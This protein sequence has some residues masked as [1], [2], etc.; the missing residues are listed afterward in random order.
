MKRSNHF[1]RVLPATLA[2]TAF[3][4]AVS[5]T[6]LTAGCG[7]GGNSA[8]QSAATRKNASMTMM[9]KWPRPEGTRKIPLA[10]N[11]ITLTIT[12]A[13]GTQTRTV[14]RPGDGLPSRVTFDSLPIRGDYTLTGVAFASAN[15]TGVALA[16]ASTVVQFTLAEPN[17]TVGL[18]L[19]TTIVRLAVTPDP[20][21]LST[22]GAN[23]V[24]L[25]SA[26]GY[27]AE[28]GGNMVPVSVV[29]FEVAD[30]AIATVST[31]PQTGITSI[32]GKA[33]GQTT[34]KAIDTESGEE[35]TVAI[36]VGRIGSRVWPAQTLDGPVRAGAVLST[37]GSVFVGGAEGRLFGFNTVGSPLPNFPVD[38]N[39]VPEQI[40]TP[41]F[42]ASDSFVLTVGDFGSVYA[43]NPNTGALLFD[44]NVNGAY[45]VANG[46]RGSRITATLAIESGSSLIRVPTKNGTIASFAYTVDG[47]G[48]VVTEAPQFQTVTAAASAVTT[49][50]IGPDNSYYV[51]SSTL[52]AQSAQ[53]HAFKQDRTRPYPAVDLDG[54]VAT[55]VALSADGTKAYVA[56]G[57]TAG[58]SVKLYGI[59]T[60]TGAIL[61]ER[62]LPTATLVSGAPA[63]GPDGT[64]Y[65]GT[66]GDVADSG[67]AG[68]Q[69][70]AVDANTGDIVPGWPFRVPFDPTV[71]LY[72]DID[73]SV[74]VGSDG[75]VYAGSLNGKLYA[76]RPNGIKRWE[77]SVFGE[78][79]T[80][81]VVGPDNT[82]YIGSDNSTFSAFR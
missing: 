52:L 31:D 80:T 45:V 20:V 41:V 74:A 13:G 55:G 61:W 21:L 9:I 10:A 14:E 39:P 3:S 35:T 56:T 79:R 59:N 18:D 63:V 65:I 12:G 38:I 1:S 67:A 2:L 72:S 82:V 4:C 17:K 43:T 75:L 58:E 40:S 23:S 68:G 37:N 78:I 36:E 64:V 34:V 57:L 53:F 73:S 47:G 30:Q 15:G 28:T 33:E 24:V 26:T 22:N 48:N 76:I 7:G 27:D 16:R 54:A 44:V 32:I 60:E 70:F 69:V 42:H 77:A 51:S 50:V 19:A 5:V 62:I 81:P 29:R 46:I 49:P 25:L 66:W 8:T 6:L 11:S 71:S